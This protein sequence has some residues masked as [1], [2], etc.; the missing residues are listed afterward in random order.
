MV[1]WLRGQYDFWNFTTHPD[2]GY[3]M[4]VMLWT[5]KVAAGGAGGAGGAESSVPEPAGALAAIAISATALLARR[6]HHDRPKDET[7]A[8][9][10]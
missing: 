8:S 2:Q 7:P 9:P 3:D 6:R 5:N 1:M 4:S 10:S